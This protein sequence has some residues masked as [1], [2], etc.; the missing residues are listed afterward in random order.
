MLISLC[1]WVNVSFF[2][3]VFVTCARIFARSYAYVFEIWCKC[4]MKYVIT[5]ECVCVCV[6]VHARVCVS[7]RLCMCG[8]VCTLVKDIQPSHRCWHLSIPS[9]SSSVAPIY[10][11][12]PPSPPPPPPSTRSPTL[13]SCLKLPLPHRHIATADRL[14]K[15]LDDS[16]FDPTGLL[17]YH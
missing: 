5:C 11:H 10:K 16:D 8:R 17:F 12:K 14:N 9:R 1:I 2:K 13:P 7:V 3:S 15:Q 6:S 4:M